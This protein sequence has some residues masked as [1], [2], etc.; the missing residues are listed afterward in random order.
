VRVTDCDL[1]YEGS[2][3]IDRHLMELADLLPF[4]AVSIYNI[5]N[6]ERFQTYVIEGPAHSGCICINGAA[7]H[8]CQ[9]GDRVIIASFTQM[10]TSEALNFQPKIVKVDLENRPK[11]IPPSIHRDPSAPSVP[12][13]R[14]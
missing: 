1:A 13:P 2:V 11:E 3:T 10:E 6:G 5:N 8:K 7:A 12:E 9:K 14:F 4:E